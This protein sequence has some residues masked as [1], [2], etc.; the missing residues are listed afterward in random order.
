MACFSSF[1]AR[2]LRTPDLTGIL[3][4]RISVVSEGVG[5]SKLGAG[6]VGFGGVE[7][8]EQVLQSSVGSGIG[9]GVES[10]FQ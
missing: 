5:E 6:E 9:Q 7:V 10:N 2:R 1:G 3:G 8:V 4:D